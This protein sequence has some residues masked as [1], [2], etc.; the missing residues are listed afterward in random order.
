MVSSTTVCLLWMI[1]LGSDM[2]VAA[3]PFGASLR[4]VKVPPV[5]V[6]DHP[7][8][9][10]TGIQPKTVFLSTHHPSSIVCWWLGGPMSHTCHEGRASCH[11]KTVIFCCIA[12]SHPRGW[13]FRNRVT[14]GS[15]QSLRYAWIWRE[16]NNSIPKDLLPISLVYLE[17]PCRVWNPIGLFEDGKLH[18]CQQSIFLNLSIA[19][20]LSVIFMFFSW[21]LLSWGKIKNKKLRSLF[22]TR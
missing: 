21:Y 8:W 10:G 7:D 11:K 12:I 1:L 22:C 3:F 6:L 17:N 16:V 18:S 19:S 4:K 20:F 5:L 15:V 2:A 14:L 9:D 13:G